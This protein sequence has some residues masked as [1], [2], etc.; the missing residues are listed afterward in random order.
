MTPRYELHTPEDFAWYKMA[1][2]NSPGG[3]HPHYGSPRSYPCQV[4][5]GLI[6]DGVL[7]GLEQ[8]PIYQHGFSYPIKGRCLNCGHVG[9]VWAIESE[10]PSNERTYEEPVL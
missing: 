2:D 9:W 4:F 1:M 6:T 8:P 10:E 7:A 5:T 3:K